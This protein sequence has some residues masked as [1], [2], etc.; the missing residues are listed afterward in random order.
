MP[1][2]PPWL[3]IACA[4]CL[5]SQATFGERDFFRHGGRRIENLYEMP[6]QRVRA[7]PLHRVV[8]LAEEVS[9]AW[10]FT[11]SGNNAPTDTVPRMAK[12]IY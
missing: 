11:A 4:S 1:R 7:E 8:H 6:D 2:L 3:L 9:D 5:V 12:I 10:A